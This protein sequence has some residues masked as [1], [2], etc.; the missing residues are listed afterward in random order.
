MGRIQ[1]ILFSSK[2]N[3]LI[4]GSL[5]G[6]IR[7]RRGLRQCNPLSSL[8]FVLIT[9]VIST[10]F[11]HA[12][13]SKILVGVR[14]GEFGSGLEVLSIIKLILYLFKG[15]TAVE[16]LNCVIGLL[17]VTYLGVPLSGRL[18]RRQDWEGMILKIKRRLSTSKMQHI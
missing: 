2:A 7:Y 18:P 5:N 9:E 13:R 16:T 12:L 6:Y 17:P 14:L 11:S 4:N 10:M 15:M 1:N 3:V 8:L